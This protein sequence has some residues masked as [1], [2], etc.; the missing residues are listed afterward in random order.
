MSKRD[1]AGEWGDLQPDRPERR[2]PYGI[3][4]DGFYQLY[5]S[6]EE[7]RREVESTFGDRNR[8]AYRC[9]ECGSPNIVHKPGATAGEPDHKRA[10]DWKCQSQPCR[11]HF[12]TPAGSIEEDAPGTQGALRGFGE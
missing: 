2:D 12:D 8:D 1:T 5:D 7:A 3:V 10:G 11:A 9:P 6:I 4:P